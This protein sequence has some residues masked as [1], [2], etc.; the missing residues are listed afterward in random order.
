MAYPFSNP[1]IKPGSPALQED[2][3]LIELRGKPISD[4][5][6]F[7]IKTV[8]RDWASQVVLVVKNLTASVRDRSDLCSIS[9]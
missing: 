2:S 1:G 7:K 8:T 9:G 3:L 4:K 5:I 6:D